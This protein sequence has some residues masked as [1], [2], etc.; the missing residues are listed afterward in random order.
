MQ[1]GERCTIR[2][3]NG[4]DNDLGHNFKETHHSRHMAMEVIKSH[5]GHCQ[6]RDK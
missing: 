5:N 3:S 1:T 2:L 4:T 6:Q